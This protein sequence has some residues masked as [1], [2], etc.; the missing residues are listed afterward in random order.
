GQAEGRWAEGV[1]TEVLLRE[2][3]LAALA[4]L[5]QARPDVKLERP[6]TIER[7]AEPAGGALSVNAY[8]HSF[9]GMTLQYLL[10]W[11]MDSGL[12]LLRER[13]QGIWR[14]LMAAPVGRGTLLAGKALAT[15]LVAL[16]QIVVT[17]GFGALVFRVGITGSVM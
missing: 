10:F 12:L 2:S 16:A 14:R 17:F 3:V 5:R 15:A 6:F 8:S 13:R 4:P 9:C 11:G 1:L 7:T